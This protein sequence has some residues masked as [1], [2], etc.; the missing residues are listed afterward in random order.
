MRISGLAS[1]MDT[2]QMIKDLMKARRAPLDKLLKTKQTETWKRDS[3]R[4]MNA[5]LLDFRNK[6]SDMRL[7]GTFS[8]FKVASSNEG[9]VSS[10][11]TG[12]GSSST[13]QIKVTQLASVSSTLS[14]GGISADTASKINPDALLKD[15]KSK[16]TAAGQDFGPAA[17]DGTHSFSLEVFQ[18]DGKMK[19]VDFSFDPNTET[20]NDVIKKVNKSGLGVTM[21]YDTASDKVSLATNHTG[22]NKGDKEI[23][24][25]G[26]FLTQTLR[27][28]DADLGKNAEFTFNGLATERTSNIFTINGMEYTLKGIGDASLT[29]TTDVDGIYD[30]IKGFIDKYNEIINKMNQKVIEKRYRA[31]DPLLNEQREAMSEKQ[32]EQWEEKAK[33]GLL[34][35][36]PLLNS[37]LYGMRRALST[38]VAG[39]SDTKFDTL[40][41]IG[42]KTMEY[43]EKGK[44]HIDEKK[45]REAITL[46][47]DKV[48]DLFTKTPTATDAEGSFYESGIGKR[49]YEQLKGYMDKITEKAGSSGT[50]VDKSVLGKSLDQLDKDIDRWEDRLKDIENR[51]YKQF[52][53]MEKAIS[54]ANSQSGWLAQQFGG[55]Q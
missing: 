16:L 24:V 54:K 45:L 33:S 37:A 50:S 25:T 27:L 38:P 22:D 4:E 51:Y 12:G 39:V 9:I 53:A 23:K 18:P 29:A 42:I 17:A 49:L 30:T 6:A 52:T 13:T 21:F 47:G 14:S 19:K 31:F 3:Y 1:G 46:N 55:G 40:S 10:K 32:I 20:L 2:E 7:Q 44:L 34:R 36:D 28:T 26:N 15:E 43:T 8:K 5:M 11:S 35:S 41:E 48:M